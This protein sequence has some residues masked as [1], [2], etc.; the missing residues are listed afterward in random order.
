M[1]LVCSWE[2]DLLKKRPLNYGDLVIVGQPGH[3][4]QMGSICGIRTVAT[5]EIATEF[6]TKIG[7]RLLL[8]EFSD[9]SDAEIAE[10]HVSGYQS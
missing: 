2:D 5:E 8:I 6:G 7:D 10:C 9:G 4:R 1:I 3:S